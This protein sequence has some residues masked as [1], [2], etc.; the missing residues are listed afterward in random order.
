MGSA[1]LENDIKKLEY[2]AR[3]EILKIT[4]Q[5]ELGFNFNQD[6]EY[7]S[8]FKDNI[9]HIR[10]VGTELILNNIFND[11]GFDLLLQLQSL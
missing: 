1:K 6:K 5:V 2:K 10:I 4:K 8:F 9:N 11:I 3:A 7:I